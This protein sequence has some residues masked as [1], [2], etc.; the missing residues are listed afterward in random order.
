MDFL[1]DLRG[2]DGVHIL[3]PGMR[4]WA[5]FT[6]L[7]KKADARGNLVPDA[8]HAARALETG[9]EWITLDRGFGRYQGLKWSHPLE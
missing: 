5:I 4:H 6:N 7:C 9:C 1:D 3:A 8:W 2:R